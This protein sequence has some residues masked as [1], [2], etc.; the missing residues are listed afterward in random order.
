MVYE[1]DR[2][3]APVICV[4]DKVEPFV[5][6]MADRKEAFVMCVLC[7][8]EALVVYTATGKMFSL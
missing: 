1:V 4:V 2:V 8:V 7:E 5:V 3:E 6:H